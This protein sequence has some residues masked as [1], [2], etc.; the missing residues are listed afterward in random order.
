MEVGGNLHGSR[1]KASR[2]TL[3]EVL[4][5]QLEVCDT[6]R[7]RWKYVEV[8][9]S[10]WKIPRNHSWKLQLMET[11]EA[12]I[13]THSGRF[14]FFLW[15]LPCISMEASTNTL[16]DK[17]TCTNFHVHFHGS[18]SSTESMGFSMDKF[19]ATPM[20]VSGNFHGSRTK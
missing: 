12:S 9:G 20:E 1:S 18:K 13:S 8:Y 4:G 15:K 11:M 5:K 19:A 16:E 7:R 3:M 6:C 2:W 17:S 14:P 10:S